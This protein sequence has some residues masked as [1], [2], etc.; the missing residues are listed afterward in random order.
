MLAIPAA[1]A[2]II[3]ADEVVRFKNQSP[4]GRRR[5]HYDKALRRVTVA[6]P[7]AAPLVFATN[8]FTS[9]ALDIAQRY[10][11]RGASSCFS[12]GS[13]STCR[14]SGFWDAAKMPSVF[15]C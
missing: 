10:K 3:L 14:S 13:S 12:N 5:N 2:D 7:D 8:D 1:A 15:K 9:T 6:R 11:E 4:G